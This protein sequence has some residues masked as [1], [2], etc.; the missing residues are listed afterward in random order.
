MEASPSL[1]S[2]TSFNSSIFL[3]NRLLK[4]TNNSKKRS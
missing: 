2:F 1:F 4:E 3:L